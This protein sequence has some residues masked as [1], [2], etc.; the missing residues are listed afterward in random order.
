MEKSCRPIQFSFFSRKTKDAELERRKVQALFVKAEKIGI[1]GSEELL[2]SQLTAAMRAHGQGQFL[3]WVPGGIE[4]QSSTIVN[5]K[6]ML[7]T[8][9]CDP[10]FGHRR[11]NIALPCIEVVWFP[12]LHTET[13]QP[14]PPTLRA[15][16]VS[17]GNFLW[18]DLEGKAFP[19]DLASWMQ[20][21]LFKCRGGPKYRKAFR[22]I[23]KDQD[24][25]TDQLPLKEP[26][27]VESSGSSPA[28]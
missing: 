23:A 7:T 9:I 17:K 5:G 20:D 1:T 8:K 27:P 6:N 18:P 22:S 10:D 4:T 21:S 12:L 25:V 11:A 14:D 28:R 3:P 24:L 16:D 19:S 2:H 15:A 26:E 13:S